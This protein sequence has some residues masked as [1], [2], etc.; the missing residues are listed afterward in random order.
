MSRSA[1][2]REIIFNRPREAFSRR[3][4]ALRLSDIFS[5]EPDRPLNLFL[6]PFR[7][8]PN[9]MLAGDYIFPP[10]RSCRAILPHESDATACASLRSK[11]PVN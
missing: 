1:W 5:I 9:S 7:F 4:R 6:P 8:Y 3:V 10:V 11:R 2:K